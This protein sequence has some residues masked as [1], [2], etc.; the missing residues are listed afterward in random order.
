M[1]TVP[2]VGEPD[3]YRRTSPIRGLDEEEDQAGSVARPPGEDVCLFNGEC[4]A[5]GSE[6]QSGDALLRCERGR[7]IVAESPAG[8]PS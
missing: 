3:P 4:F 7:W 8:Q 6:V 2:Q 5:A 1:E